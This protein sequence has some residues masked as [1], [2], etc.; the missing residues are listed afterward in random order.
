MVLRSAGT[1]SRLR[2]VRL[3]VGTAGAVV[4]DERTGRAF[5]TDYG[6]GKVHMFDTATG[7]LLR[8]VTTG[9]GTTGGRWSP[10]SSPS[11]L[12]LD[13]RANRLYMVDLSSNMSILDTQNGAVLHSI[14][15]GASPVA[16]AIDPRTHRAF[17]ANRDE[18]TVRVLDA[19]DGHTLRTINVGLTPSS[20]AVDSRSGR[21]FVVGD[22]SAGGA[23]SVVDT[24]RLRLLGTIAIGRFARRVVVD[25]QT[26]RAF[27]TDSGHDGRTPTVSVLD[28]RTGRLL[29]ATA[30]GA[31]VANPSALPLDNGLALD[32]QTG[33]VFVADSPY[34]TVSVLSAA[35]G[36]LLRT[37]SVGPHPRAMAVDSQARLVL[38]AN[39]GNTD[40]N[41][42][43]TGSGSVSVL[44]ARSG[45]VLRTIVVGID[46]IAVSV[47]ARS[48][49]AFII[50]AGGAVRVRDPWDWLPPSLR[51]R[52]PFI[53]A[54]AVHTRTVRASMTI[55]DTSR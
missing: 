18:G 51:R 10:W 8:T 31:P 23:V 49:R 17:L 42:T 22:N 41:G 11:A 40:S 7:K 27:V 47:D 50:N 13:E 43:W 28:A 53:P 2:T 15:A 3:N 24:V 32:E 12:A 29:R 5:V 9:Y 34:N 4:V 54:P 48:G 14:G 21:A 20:L 52:L 25:E 26:R 19:A 44:D 36:R 45:S 30:Y 46:P 39:E 33:R 37:I 38:L 16:L 35:T 1:S 6:S 55:I